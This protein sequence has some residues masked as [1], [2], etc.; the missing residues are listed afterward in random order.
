MFLS[1]CHNT[2]VRQTDRRRDGQKGLAVPCTALHAVAWY[3]LASPWSTLRELCVP[4][5]ILTRTYWA[6]HEVMT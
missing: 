6:R 3:K 2:P 1:F 4:S 5:I